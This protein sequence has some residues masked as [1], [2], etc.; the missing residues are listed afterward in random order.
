MP[1]VEILR[2][3]FGQGD[4]TKS[5]NLTVL[6]D[7]L[8]KSYFDTAMDR[9]VGQSAVCNITTMSRI[10]LPNVRDLRRVA[11]KTRSSTKRPRLG[12]LLF[13]GRNFPNKIKLTGTERL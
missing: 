4:G 2:F 8:C 7:H 11:R 13:L 6:L 3:P 9:A 1:S 12:D 10:E 5:S